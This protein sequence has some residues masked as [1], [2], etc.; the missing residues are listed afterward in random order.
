RLLRRS[1]DA[2]PFRLEGVDD[3][4]DKRLLRPDEGQVDILVLGE[5]AQVLDIGRSDGDVLGDE[6]RPGVAGGAID[7]VDVAAVGELPAKGILAPAAADDEDLQKGLSSRYSA[8]LSKRAY[9]GKKA[10]FTVPVGPF[11]CLAM[12]TSASSPP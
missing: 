3:P 11:R 9:L 12:I 6:R 7:L 5:Q 10:S 1:E 4:Q 2:Q 8:R